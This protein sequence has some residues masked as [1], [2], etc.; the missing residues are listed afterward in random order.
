MKLCEMM[1]LSYLRYFSEA[2]A[3]VEQYNR[4]HFIVH[5]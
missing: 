1:Q 4:M 3:V 2:F 5:Q